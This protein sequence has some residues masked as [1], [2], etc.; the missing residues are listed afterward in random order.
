ML[1]LI[2]FKIIFSYLT[3]AFWYIKF[4]QMSKIVSRAE[5]KGILYVKY[6]LYTEIIEYK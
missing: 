3:V 1:I 2:T 5:N 6:T 4:C